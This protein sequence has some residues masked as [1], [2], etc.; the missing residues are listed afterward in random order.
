MKMHW[1]TFAHLCLLL[2]A[3]SCRRGDDPRFDKAGILQATVEG[4][5]VPYHQQF[6]TA[7][8]RLQDQVA[9]FATAPDSAQLTLVRTAW[10]S[11]D[12]AWKRCEMFELGRIKEGYLFTR[13][14]KWP[15]SPDQIGDV[16]AGTD[17]LDATAIERVGSSGKGLSALEY[18]LY[19]QAQAITLA[20]LT[21][22]SGA[23]RR[24]AYLIALTQNLQDKATELFQI[25]APEGSDYGSEFAQSTASGI[26]DPIS[27]LVNAMIAQLEEIAKRKLGTPIGKFDLGTVQ[28]DALEAGRS[29]QSLTLMQENLA[30]LEQGYLGPHGDDGIDAIVRSMRAMHGDVLLADKLSQQFATTRAAFAAIVGPIENTLLTQHAQLENAYQQCK[31]LLV[32]LKS[33]LESALSITVTVSDADGD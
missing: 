25:W 9:I 5:I 16:L 28:L 11:C 15:I 14:G 26:D 32:L 29:L 7:A 27:M 6:E 10:V 31:A 2:A 18:V 12:L 33:D 8:M 13:I 19:D 17:P 24:M 20:Q 23:T 1:P 21:T 22:D 30:A 4:I 3:T